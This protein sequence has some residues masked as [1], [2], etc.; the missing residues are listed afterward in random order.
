MPESTD[1]PA[2][3]DKPPTAREGWLSPAIRGT[4]GTGIVALLLGAAAVPWW[5]SNPERISQI[6]AKAAPAVQGTVGFDRVR[7]GWM[8]PL[9]LEGL[10]IVPPDG[11]EPPIT[12]SRVE[13]SHGLLA[14]LFSAGDLGQIAVEGLRVELA[15][16]ERHHSNLER[17]FPPPV[18]GEAS[19]RSGP[20][21]SP[22][23]MRLDVEEAVVRI[24]APWTTE[25]WVSEPITV[26]AAL[27]PVPEG[28]SEWVVEPTQLLTDAVMAPPVA[29]GVLSYVAPVLADTTRAAGRFSLRLDGARLPVGDPRSGSLSGV[30]AMHEVVVGPGPLAM[31]LINSLP[32]QLPAPPAIRVADESHV[33][34]RLTDRRVWHEGLEF[35]LPL[36]GEGRRLD[37]RSQGSVGLDDRSLA[38]KLVLPIPAD[39][40]QDRPLLAA[41]AGKTISVGVAGELGDPQI[42]FDGSIKQAAGQ[43]A[44]DLI[45][46]IRNGAAPPVAAPGTGLA[47]G[48]APPPAPAQVPVA[49][50]DAGVP[51]R[52]N[53]PTAAGQPPVASGENTS[54]ADTIVDI[55]GGVLEEVA[56]RRAEREANGEVPPPRRGRLRQ[57]LQRPGLTAP[58]PEGQPPLVPVQP[59]APSPAVVPPPPV[60]QPPTR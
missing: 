49:G 6:I 22:V 50:G 42:V 32:I 36:P 18:A 24:T 16:D 30:L 33:N 48:P 41:L 56:R 45:D 23:R 4:L 3:A 11:G 1:R 17:I 14:M 20:R 31:N 13:V 8:G 7:L 54:T 25:P 15:F 21:S 39:L 40:R 9:V 38:I 58:A 2:S 27:K 51:P 52:P 35:G 26:H 12:A 29:W 57:R 19:G 37:V 47:P 34:F 5:L 10:R 60:P 44:A 28:W 46:R 53:P 55:V 59:A 43:V